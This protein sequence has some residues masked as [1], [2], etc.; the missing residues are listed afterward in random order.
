[1]RRLQVPILGFLNRSMDIEF[2]QSSH[3]FSRLFFAILA[4]ILRPLLQ[5]IEKV[6]VCL[7]DPSFC[8]PQLYFLQP[9][10]VQPRPGTRAM[11]PFKQP[12]KSSMWKRFQNS[13]DGR[14][15]T[16]TSPTR[17]PSSTVCKSTLSM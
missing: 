8:L 10:P 13:R 1:R 4:F 14:A 2:P 3:L 5:S 11:L 7:A 15:P 6:K 12:R 9:S 16:F 17:S